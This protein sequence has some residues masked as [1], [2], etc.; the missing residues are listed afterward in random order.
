MQ[1]FGHF[2]TQSNTHALGLGYEARNCGMWPLPVARSDSRCLG[3]LRSCV[4]ALH[5]LSLSRVETYLN[6][7]QSHSDCHCHCHTEATPARSAWLPQWPALRQAASAATRSELDS[8]AAAAAAAAVASTA[9]CL[10]T[11]R[12][13]WPLQKLALRIY[14]QKHKKK[15]N[16]TE[17]EKVKV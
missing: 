5:E 8:A 13:L 17:K 10:I 16:I 1:I 6:L 14:I 11:V 15:I 3:R 12:L 9:A 2:Y 4:A 7:R